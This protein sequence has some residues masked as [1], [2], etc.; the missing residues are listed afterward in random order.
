MTFSPTTHLRTA[1]GAGR[2]YA[3]ISTYQ[4][5][6]GIRNWILMST[7]W[8]TYWAVALAVLFSCCPYQVVGH[9]HHIE[10]HC[11]VV[12]PTLMWRPNLFHCS[13][14]MK[15]LFFFKTHAIWVFGARSMVCTAIGHLHFSDQIQWTSLKEASHNA[16]YHNERGIISS[17][18]LS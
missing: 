10:E 5:T 4:A 14:L 9:M 2:V 3:T 6:C 7:A 1:Y 11:P 8:D 18:K 12:R 13:C 15:N 16:P 17:S